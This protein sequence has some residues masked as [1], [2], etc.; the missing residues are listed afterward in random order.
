MQCSCVIAWRASEP[1]GKLLASMTFSG[2][3][4]GARS[5]NTVNGLEP[6]F[7]RVLENDRG[8]FAYLGGQL[9]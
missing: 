1:W 4:S 8:S 2:V 9:R 7:E 5:H 3:S 6:L